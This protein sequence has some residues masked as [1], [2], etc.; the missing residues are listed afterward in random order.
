[1]RIL[2]VEDDLDVLQC[3][4]SYFTERGHE[5]LAA[6][7]AAEAVEQLKKGLPPA[8]AFV[9]LLLPNSHGRTVIEELSRLQYPTRVVVI[10][11]CDDLELRKELIQHGVHRYLFKPITIRDIDAVLEGK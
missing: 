7:T 8:L 3:I 11:A 5:V 4:R 2:V 10:T 1:M 6:C 9:D